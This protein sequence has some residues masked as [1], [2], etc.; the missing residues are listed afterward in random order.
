MVEI[1]FPAQFP[2]TLARED[3]Q[4]LFQGCLLRRGQ[5]V[6]ETRTGAAVVDGEAEAI[7]GGEQLVAG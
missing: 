2:E 3:L 4:K 7:Y 5:C 6:N 1:K